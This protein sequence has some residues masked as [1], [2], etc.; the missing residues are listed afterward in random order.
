MSQ[1]TGRSRGLSGLSRTDSDGEE[2]RF[3]TTHLK[4]GRR[5][6]E[7]YDLTSKFNRNRT[8]E[9]P[10]DS[11]VNGTLFSFVH[12]RV[13]TSISSL[14]IFL[15]AILIGVHMNTEVVNAISG[16]HD[17][18]EEAM[19]LGIEISFTLFFSGELF[20]RALSERR[21]FWT[22]TERNWN[23]LDLLL[24]LSSV[25]DLVL[26]EAS[27]LPDM[28]FTRT[29]RVL[30]FM[31]ILR[32]VRVIR[33]FQSLRLMV[34]SILNSMAALLWVFCM[35]FCVMYFFASIFVHGVT[36]YFKGSST[37]PNLSTALSQDFGSVLDALLSLFGAIC[38]GQD[39]FEFM[40][41]LLDLDWFYGCTFI[42]YI[43]FMIFGV[44]N[45]V[46]GTFVDTAYQAS[47]RDREY[48]VQCEVDR[49]KK[50]MED[51]KTFFNE[52]DSD[53]SGMLTLEE[54]ETHLQQDRV[55][56]YFQAL[57]LDIS[58]ARALFMLLDSDGSNKIELE[59]FIGGCMRMK[60]DAKSIDVNMLL[61]TNE[62]MISKWTTFMEFCS[63]KFDRIEAA[64]GI[65]PGL[66]PKGHRAAES[67]SSSKQAPCVTDNLASALTALS[68]VPLTSDSL[69]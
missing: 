14:V 25:A 32:I 47:Q 24:V 58:Q 65:E 43:F 50:Y 21:L 44:L 48:V 28:T 45:V 38:G 22:G 17:P 67:R 19:W 30:R 4:G 2:K 56:A 68:K 41:P 52:A 60:G 20:L 34:Y 51:I 54:F 9:E 3:T 49:N 26:S 33:F 6:M 64:L 36:E 35:L 59:E 10:V 39:W 8:V 11:V 61:Y 37:S 42:A 18:D 23:L 62:K 1:L 16:H 13:F 15:N 5:M 12:G 27:K 63:D 46:V 55:K 57:E 53:R 29:L 66:E 31:R 40:M 7:L 69:S